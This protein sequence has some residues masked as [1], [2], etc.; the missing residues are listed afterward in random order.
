MEFVAGDE[1]QSMKDRGITF[2]AVLSAPILDIIPN[3]SR[4]GQILLIV[5]LEDYAVVTPCKP[6]PDGKWLL[7]TAYPSRKHTKRY[8]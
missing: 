1:K 5:N 4:P 7:T 8:L 2:D 6:L 3:P